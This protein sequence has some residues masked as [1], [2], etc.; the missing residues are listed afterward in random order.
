MEGGSIWKGMLRIYPAK[1]SGNTTGL[2]LT[3]PSLFLFL[4]FQT[5]LKGGTML[6]SAPSPELRSVSILYVH[7]THRAARNWDLPTIPT[8]APFPATPP[9][10]SGCSWVGHTRLAAA[11]SIF[12]TKLPCPFPLRLPTGRMVL[13]HLWAPHEQRSSA[14]PQHCP[15][16]KPGAHF[17]NSLLTHLQTFSL[18]PTVFNNK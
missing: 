13:E 8:P 1:V 5:P 18:T 4:L 15:L 3:P 11:V 12:Y 14:G 10:E 16:G 17:K 9:A 7:C 2:L 6:F